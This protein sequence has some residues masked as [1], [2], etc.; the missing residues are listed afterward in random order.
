MQVSF[1]WYVHQHNSHMMVFGSV[2]AI[3]LELRSYKHILFRCIYEDLIA[4]SV[5]YEYEQ[6]ILL[7]CSFSKFVRVSVEEL[8]ESIDQLYSTV[9]SGTMALLIAIIF[10]RFFFGTHNCG[11]PF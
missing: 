9:S 4:R 3:C 11:S 6:L 5:S 2:V 1:N 10:G 7:P 8:I